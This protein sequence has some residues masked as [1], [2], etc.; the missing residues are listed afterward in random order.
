MIQMA[1]SVKLLKKNHKD[2]KHYKAR[3]LI[4]M[5]QRVLKIADE[6]TQK[7]VSTAIE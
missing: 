4:G 6:N 3:Q 5:I 2:N 7:M 1:K